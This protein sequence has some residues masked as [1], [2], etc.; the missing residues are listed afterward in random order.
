[1]RRIKKKEKIFYDR[2]SDV[3]WFLVKSGEEEEYLEVAPGINVELGKK[4]DLLGIEI[5]N[6]SKIIKP[7]FVGRNGR[8]A[9]YPSV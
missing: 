9:L 5:L 4:G 7:L 2:K 6:A 1:M 8:S 3:L